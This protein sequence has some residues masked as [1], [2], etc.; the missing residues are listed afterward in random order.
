MMRHAEDGVM[1]TFDTND[2]I[3]ISSSAEQ[4]CPQS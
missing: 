1:L 2:E 3:I 4:F